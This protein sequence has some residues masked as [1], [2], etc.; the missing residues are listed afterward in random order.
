MVVHKNDIKNTKIKYEIRAVLTLYRS[1]DLITYCLSLLLCNLVH[2]VLV[3]YTSS[4]AVD[5]GM[6][7]PHYHDGFSFFI[8]TVTNF[9]LSRTNI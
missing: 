9:I 6:G 7:L 3:P 1:T 4:M 2:A 8:S 5:N